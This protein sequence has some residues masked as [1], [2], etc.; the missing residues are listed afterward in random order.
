MKGAN[1]EPT[2]LEWDRREAPNSPDIS[3][4]IET[5]LDTL[6]T[7]AAW[8]GRKDNGPVGHHQ[9]L[10]RGTVDASVMRQVCYIEACE[11]GIFTSS[12]SVHMA[13]PR[14]C[15]YPQANIL[16]EA[17]KLT[18]GHAELQGAA[19]D[20][21]NIRSG[22]GPINLTLCRSSS[23]KAIPTG[24]DHNTESSTANIRV[25]PTIPNVPKRSVWKRLGRFMSLLWPRRWK[26]GRRPTVSN[27]PESPTNGK[28]PHPR[29]GDG[30]DAIVPGDVTATPG[31]FALSFA[32]DPE[33]APPNPTI[34]QT[35]VL[36]MLPSG[37]GA[38]IWKPAP[39]AP[40]IGPKGILLG[41]LGKYDPEGGFKRILNIWDD[42]QA[43]RQLGA[44]PL[45]SRDIS[46]NPEDIPR[47]DTI[48]RGASCKKLSYSDPGAREAHS[49]EFQCFASTGAVLAATSSAELEELVDDTDLREWLI[50]NYEFLYECASQRRRGIE[51]LYLIT[52]SIKSDTWALG[53]FQEINPGGNNEMRL[54]AV[55]SRQGE[56]QRYEWSCTAA[57]R[58]RVGSSGQAGLKNQTLFVRGFKIRFSEAF[59]G[60]MRIQL[61]QHNRHSTDNHPPFD[62]NQN[63]SHSGCRDHYTG[64][65]PP[66]C[67]TAG[68]SDSIRSPSLSNSFSLG[69]GPKGVESDHSHLG[70]QS[71]NLGHLSGWTAPGKAQIQVFPSS[72][73]DTYHPSDLINAHLLE[74]SNAEVAFCHDDEW[75]S[76]VKDTDMTSDITVKALATVRLGIEIR[77][78]VASLAK[79]TVWGTNCTNV[80]GLGDPTCHNSLDDALAMQKSSNDGLVSY[81]SAT[82]MNLRQ[83]TDHASLKGSYTTHTTANSMNRDEVVSTPNHTRAGSTIES[84]KVVDTT[85]GCGQSLG[86]NDALS[87]LTHLGALRR[88]WLF[89]PFIQEV[90]TYVNLPSSFHAIKRATGWRDPLFLWKSKLPALDEN[91]PGVW[92][93]AEVPTRPSVFGVLWDM[94]GIQAKEAEEHQVS[95]LLIGELLRLSFMT[96]PQ[97]M[98]NLSGRCKH[99]AAG[100]RMSGTRVTV[101]C[102]THGYCMGPRYKFAGGLDI[103]HKA[104]LAQ[105]KAAIPTLY[106]TS[107]SPIAV[108]DARDWPTMLPA[109]IGSS[110]LLKNDIPISSDLLSAF[111]TALGTLAAM[112]GPRQTIQRRLS[113]IQEH[114]AMPLEAAA[115]AFRLNRPDKALE[116]LEQGR[117]LVWSQQ[118]QLRTPLDELEGHDQRLAKRV[119]S[120]SK[121]LQCAQSSVRQIFFSAEDEAENRLHL[122]R[123]W[124]VLL[125]QVRTIPGFEA[126][127]RPPQCLALVQHLPSSGPVVVINVHG[128]RCDAMALLDG[129]EEPLHIPLPNFTSLKADC[130]RSTLRS[131]R[132][133][134]YRGTRQP[135]DSENTQ[136]NGSRAAGSYQN[137]T[138]E[139]RPVCEDSLRGVFAGLWHYVVKPV[140]IAL[141]YTKGDRVAH[142]ALPR[143]WWC[144]TGTLSFLPLHAAGVYMGLEEEG[145]V[146]YAVSSYTP[147]V[148]ALVQRVRN[149]F[150]VDEQGSGLFLTCQ[151]AVQGCNPIPGTAREVDLIHSQA[152][153]NGVR[154][155]K[156][157]GSGVSAE[158]CLEYMNKYSSIH[159]ACHAFQNAKD[160]LQSAF[161]FQDG[162][163]TLD[164]IMQRN[165][166]NA[167]FAFL[168][169]CQTSAGEESLS[170]EAVH[171][172]AGMLAAGYRRVVATMWEIGDNQAGEVANEFYQYIFSRKQAG[173][174]STRFDGTLSAHALHYATQQ[175]RHRLDGSDESLLAWASYVH[176]GY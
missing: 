128:S 70:R 170:D 73:Q 76:Q 36:A 107:S 146:D 14:D 161:R 57:A 64:R 5:L 129:V 72:A 157:E 77:N 117:C 80:T 167:D 84:P 175:L 114:S 47:G 65:A 142:E 140:L 85:I 111:G 115:T 15:V 143:I 164:M 7:S 156:V 150:P 145:T 104:T 88:G 171:L 9:I 119:D 8:S 86:R 122:A 48:V 147:T 168:S 102:N 174:T 32:Q 124:D 153:A 1:L 11:V 81:S 113:L 162:K 58:A 24:C 141:G 100:K 130:Y 46:T 60:R 90:K 51:T 120:V 144:P 21:I 93:A 91:S 27:A 159:L 2:S 105:G 30:A 89:G 62:D 52:A 152:M 92:G 109:R 82:A 99:I 166:K 29:T 67:Q 163:L 78:G 26:R 22:T 23:T 135:N 123:E 83:S 154:S 34:G 116:W 61:H 110:R 12:I 54:T 95:G 17:Q 131:V 31:E 63:S 94:V 97:R 127:L 38:A 4:V 158:Q 133:R 148:T 160:P 39:V 108:G 37:K 45:P 101:G 20:V 6:W 87:S 176:F 35:Y 138:R 59:Q 134:H 75:R 96:K 40:N 66:S 10:A 172:A 112:A 103:I 165:I 151:P 69:G 125:T 13:S 173:T 33:S 74:M 28:R 126:F 56:L 169:A 55:P 132:L 155:L 16:P 106:L 50:H 139:N 18:F 49:F 19:R 53:A 42:E 25:S 137:R 41:D 43:L 136:I 3:C 68:A 98:L 71:Q 44:S 121:Q 118:S 149:D 79:A